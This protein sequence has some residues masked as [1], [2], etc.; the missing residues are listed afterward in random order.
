MRDV[1]LPIMNFRFRA[2]PKLSL[3]QRQ[4]FTCA[5]H[6]PSNRLA[7]SPA[8]RAG[9]INTP[10][11]NLDAPPLNE[12][13]HTK[14]LRSD[15]GP[16]VIGQPVITK[17]MEKLGENNTNGNHRI[18]DG[19]LRIKGASPNLVIH[20]LPRFHPVVGAQGNRMSSFM[21]GNRKIQRLGEQVQKRFRALQ[22]GFG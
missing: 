8:F 22:V 13:P 15:C 4:A 18:P 11:I 16:D 21:R 9:W 2:R 10:L 6:I 20:P 17:T 5:I 12:T 3:F 7:I 14:Q 1:P 19:P